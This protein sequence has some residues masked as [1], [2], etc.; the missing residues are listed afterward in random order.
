MYGKLFASAFSGSMVGSGLNVYAV[1]AYVIANTKTDGL[2]E[3]NPPILAAIL[4]CDVGEVN[5]ALKHLLSPDPISRNKQ[6]EGRRLIQRS[7][8]VYEVPTYLEYRAIRDED[9]RREYMRKYMADYRAQKGQLAAD[10]TSPEKPVNVNVNT[11]KPRLAHTEGEEDTDTEKETPLSDKSLGEK[12]LFD[13]FWALYP[14][15]KGRKAAEVKWR[16]RHLDAKAEEIMADVRRRMTQDGDW[17][18]G[19]VPHGS[20][21]VN[22]DG[23]CD[24]LKPLKNGNASGDAF[25][26]AL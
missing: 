22:G 13:Q 24:G 26:G 19:Y 6:H 23:W 3:I 25:L 4:G 16:A 11:C 9:G 7:T 18:R 17:V 2:V 12:S 14:V 21:Y 15:K 20:S 8:F 5:S 10:S 1:W